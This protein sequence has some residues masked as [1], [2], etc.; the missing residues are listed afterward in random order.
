MFPR[1]SILMTTG[2]WGDWNDSVR[3]QACLC[4]TDTETLEKLDASVS[5]LNDNQREELCMK[6][7]R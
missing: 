4:V 7:S 1:D 5:V 3:S 6:L 2:R